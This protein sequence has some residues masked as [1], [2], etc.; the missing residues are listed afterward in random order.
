[1]STKAWTEGEQAGCDGLPSS[2]NPY[3]E[4][5]TERSHWFWGRSLMI[6]RITQDGYEP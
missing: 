4:G 5:T 6:T 1:M 3:P 2:D